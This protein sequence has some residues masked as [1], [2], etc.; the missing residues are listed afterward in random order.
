[1]NDL[2]YEV[3]GQ[4]NELSFIPPKGTFQER[5]AWRTG[6]QNAISDLIGILWPGSPGEKRL[7]MD[8]ILQEDRR[9]RHA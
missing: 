2:N 5:L 8:D 9:R 6:Y 7:T 1:M 3:V 4:L